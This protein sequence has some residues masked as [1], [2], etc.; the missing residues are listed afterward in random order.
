M[1]IGHPTAGDVCIFTAAVNRRLHDPAG[2]GWRCNGIFDRAIMSTLTVVGVR[3][4]DVTQV[5]GRTECPMSQ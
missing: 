1:R 3:A 5:R 4:T 2:N